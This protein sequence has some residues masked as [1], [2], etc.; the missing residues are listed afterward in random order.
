MPFTPTHVVA[1]IPLWPLRR[2]LPFAALAIGSMVPD[3]ALFFPYIDYSETHSAMG[4][5]TVCLPMGISLFLLFELVM[6]RPMTGLLPNYVERRIQSA[7]RLPTEPEMIVHFRFYAKVALAIVI[8][9]Y[10]HQIWDAFTHQGRWGTRLVPFLNSQIEIGGYFV[11]GY[12]AFQY[13]STFIG[14]PFLVMIAAFELNRTA[15]V[16]DQF[17]IVSG[18]SKSI[19]ASLIVI[20]PLLVGTYAYTTYPTAYQALGMTI[21]RSGAITLVGSLVYCILFQTFT[22]GA[23]IHKSGKDRHR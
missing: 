8:G 23:A 20:I 13:A 12:K 10:T 17:S 4:V 21:K 6:R 9:A 14:L 11:P 16:S 2:F 15:P 3:L 1:V 22:N 18:K 5:F 7:P 19:A